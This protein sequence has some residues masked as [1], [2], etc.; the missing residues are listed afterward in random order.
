MTAAKDWLAVFRGQGIPEAT[1]ETAMA[2]AAELTAVAERLPRDPH[3]PVG[4]GDL[5]PDLLKAAE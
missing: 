3:A 2:T 4:G 5:A 1:I